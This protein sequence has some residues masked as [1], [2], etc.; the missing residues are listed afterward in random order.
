MPSIRSK[1]VSIKIQITFVLYV[2]AVH[3]RHPS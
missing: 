1:T 3:L 2:V